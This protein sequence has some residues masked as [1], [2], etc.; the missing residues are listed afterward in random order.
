MPRASETIDDATPLEGSRIDVGA[1]IGWLLRTHR[2][3]AGLSLRQM[4]A[5]LGEVGV[6]ASAATLS[7]IEGEGN[8]TS[9]LLDGYTTVLGLPTG[10]LWTAA[11]MLR[12]SFSYAPPATDDTVRD[13]DS[14]SAACDAVMGE[15]PTGG[16][17]LIFA[18]HHATPAGFGLPYSLVTPLVRRLA[19]ECARGSRTA[20]AVRQEAL[21]LLMKGPYRDHL[22]SA[23]MELVDE[24]DNQSF[25]LLTG[26]LGDVPT[27]EVV[28]WAG[29]RLSGATR[30]HVWGGSYVLQGLLVGG[31]VTL[32]TWMEVV[33]AVEAGWRAAGDDADRAAAL[34][35]L[36]A[37]LPLA[38]QAQLPTD[39]WAAPTSPR[40]TVRWDRAAD[41]DH[42]TFARRIAREVTSRLDQPAEPMLE[43]L[44]FE[45]CFEPR[46]T[47]LSMAC[48]LTSLS[49]FAHTTAE[50][51]LERLRSAPDAESRAAALRLAVFCH[52]GR[53]VPGQDRL[54]ADATPA[55]LPQVLTLL[56][57]SGATL[58][59]EALRRGLAGDATA[60][61]Q[62]LFCL[63]M[64]GDPRLATLADDPAQPDDVRRGARWWLRAGP[65]IVD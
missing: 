5:S 34:R 23:L 39:V 17:W 4:S 26:V 44:V 16:D 55:E 10:Q 7:R 29:R 35:E 61:R 11:A 45:G 32:E 18:R 19:Q 9:S 30:F 46:G 53:S 14:Y 12:R 3:V 1:R 65:R 22:A 38:V 52:D 24:P 15:A 63:G 8:A 51:V 60:V 54:L 57:R 21:S 2:T 50:V 62:T 31:G 49:A 13:L 41:N 56:G 40:A 47:R 20:R 59:E 6:R 27:P 28:H 37:T 33:P 25:F 36:C 48:W 58:P 64:A 43:R 42:Y